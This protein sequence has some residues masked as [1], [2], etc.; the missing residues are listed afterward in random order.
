MTRHPTRAVTWVAASILLPA[1]GLLALF[2]V[3]LA[4]AGVGAVQL[5]A[6]SDAIDTAGS[7]LTQ[8]VEAALPVLEE[9]ARAQ[10]NTAP[11]ERAVE[12]WRSTPPGRPRYRA[13]RGVVR[14]VQQ[15]AQSLSPATPQSDRLLIEQ[16]L[17]RLQAGEAALNAGVSDWESAAQGPFGQ[18]ALLLHWAQARPLP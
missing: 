10:A 12:D 2:V 6:A 3:V 5:H 8:R 17:T 18:L 4:L 7:E 11:V 9:L 1:V 16:R 14:A 15:A 13:A